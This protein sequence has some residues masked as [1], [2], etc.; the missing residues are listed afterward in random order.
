MEN[1]QITIL[2]NRIS[3]V[4]KLHNRLT[5]IVVHLYHD[6]QRMKKQM[7]NQESINLS[8][9]NDEVDKLVIG[10]NTDS[11]DRANKILEELKRVQ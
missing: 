3:E 7:Q 6:N 2:K 8:S 11:N 9:E 4:E 5:A 1:K 10:S